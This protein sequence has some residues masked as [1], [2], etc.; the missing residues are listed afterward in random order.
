MTETSTCP[1]CGYEG[2][3]AFSECPAC[4]II[5]SKFIELEK[6]RE[7]YEKNEATGARASLEKLKE[8][9]GLKISQKKEWGE[10]LTGFE[11][12]NRYS[13]MDSWSNPVFE[14]EE[15]SGSL[16]ALASRFFLTHLRPFTITLFSENG[17]A[18]FTIERSFRFY[19]HRVTVSKANGAL[20]GSV[21]RR[22]A[23]FRRIYTVV[24]KAGREAFDLFGPILQPWTFLI[25]KQDE[26]LGKI[27][28]KWSGLGKEAFT[29]ADNFG[30][31]FPQSLDNDEKA[32]LLGA[33][34]LIDFVHFEKR[35]N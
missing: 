2:D 13:V 33:V 7:T 34:F 5:V 32:L 30:I 35:S 31:Q 25:K 8:V 17:T 4:G 14:A 19:F 9:G 27:V 21:T 29:A 11:T 10:I 28:K 18:L 26:E 15:Q 12:R 16:G 6:D 23:L 20:L 24:D 22:F 1:K 3:Q